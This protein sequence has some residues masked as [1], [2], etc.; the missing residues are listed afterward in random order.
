MSGS[1]SSRPETVA[2]GGVPR[3][4][5]LRTALSLGA[6]FA[7]GSLP[8]FTTG[9]AAVT[10]PGAPTL[11]PDSQAVT[12]WY[13]APGTE[14]VIMEQGLPIGNGRL[15]AMVTGDPSHDALYLSDATLWTGDANASLGSDGQFAY[16]STDFGSF[17]LLAQAYL[18]IPA[19]TTAAINGYRRALD[20]SNG[21]VT[22]SYQLG[23]V[24]Y[25]REVY[26]SRPD[27]VIVIRLTQSGGGSYTGSLTLTGTRGE[28][29]SADTATASVSFDAA[30]PNSLRYATVVQAVGTGGTVSAAG[31]QL[32]FADCRE[33]LLVVS[34]GTNYKAD[35]SIGY[36]DTSIAPL[37]VARHRA[38][39]AA[40]VAGTALLATHVADYQRL[41]QAMTVNLGASSAAQRAMD[42]ASRLTA[43]AAAGSAPDPELEASFLHFGRYLMICGSR[44][45]LPINLQ[46]LWIDRNDPDWMSDY[47]TDINL[48]MNYW[49]PDRTGLSECFD[50]LTDYC[51]AQLP[52][53]QATTRDLFQDTRNGFRNS[54]GKVAGWTLAISTNIWGGNGWWWHPAGSAWISNSLYQHYQYTQD[55]GHLERIYPLLKGACEFWEARLITTTVPDPVT[56]GTRQVLVD[57]HDWSPEQGPTDAIGI[58]Y[59]Q[60]LVWQLFRNYQ[61]AAAAL[62]RDAGYASTIAGLQEQLYLP[63]ISATSGWLEEWMSNDNLGE[64]THRHLSPLIGLFPGDRINLQ[65]SPPAL[66]EAATALLTARG[67]VS[68]GWGCAWR[69]LCWA[70]LKNADKAYQLVLTVMQPSVNFANGVGINMFNMYSFGN[71]S[72]FQNDGNFGAPSAMVEMLVQSR[73]GRVELLPALPSAWAAS[74]SVTGIGVRGGLSVDLSWASGQVTTATLRGSA[75][76]STTVVFGAWS[77]AVT[78]PAG[79]SVTVTPPAQSTVCQ[80]VNRLSGKAIDVP[81]ASTVAGTT[82]IQ[83]TPGTAANQ[84]FR[85]TGVGG[86]TYE[87]DCTHTALAWD[88]NG[89][90]TADGATLIEWTPT[91]GTNQQWRITDT[92]DGYITI[93]SVRSGK[94]LGVTQDSTADLATIEQQS[95]NSGPGQQWRRIPV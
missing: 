67:M 3:R 63:E 27:D 86:D 1:P 52:G 28:T 11:V 69:A 66:I 18:E 65:D 77:Q 59:A 46:G 75:G 12:L 13:T 49:L 71:R 6:L 42:T 50:T 7:L 74:G 81:G 92:G 70:Q 54:S 83:Y 60:E 53:W 62:G 79:G 26:S 61:E 82:L 87:I 58:T 31:A 68:F 16:D 88:I 34:G 21:L 35:A 91:H 43:R 48:Q 25:R 95:A 23:G 89:G 38:A 32:S 40:T 4:A 45:S 19:H 24:T 9:A 85:F 73:P 72:V 33:V 10:R 93:A 78:I 80:L 44:D 5:V 94:V 15:G 17:G 20:L 47:H 39:A 56:G 84:H 51:I 8:E 41:Q 14:A 90:S 64:T 30:L 37:T 36:K 29:V 55:T 57:D 2:A 76:A 22:A